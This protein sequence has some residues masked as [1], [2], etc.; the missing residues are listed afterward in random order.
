MA[1]TKR[2]AS[3]A[4]ALILVAIIASGCNQPYSQA[5]DVTNTPIDPN[6]LF[7][8]PL[9]GATEMSDV[10]VF[11]TQTA[12]AGN[13]ALQ[14]T[15]TLAGA[16][17]PT[18]TLTPFVSLPILPTSTPTATLAVSGPTNTPQA[19]GPISSPLPGGSEYILR[20]DEFPYCIARR[21]DVHPND[22]LRASQLTSP[23]IYYAGIRLTI[24]SGSKWPVQDLGPRSLRAHPA[25]YTVT[26]NGDTSVFGVACKFGDVTPEQIASQ[27]NN[28]S[29][30]AALTIGQTLNIP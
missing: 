21:F 24:P 5:P 20:V 18:A 3:I 8:T 16:Q 29:L 11:A 4:S 23:D 13:P 28:I 15:T 12:R 25:T 30:N 7:A 22:L 19:A 26:G 14:A 27:N 17:N 10:E 6:S 9:S 1:G 2:G